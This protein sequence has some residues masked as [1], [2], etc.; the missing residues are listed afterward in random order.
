KQLVFRSNGT[1]KHTLAVPQGQLS[2]P[3]LGIRTHREAGM[4]TTRAGLGP[5]PCDSDACVDSDDPVGVGEQGIDI[6]LPYFRQIRSKLRD[7]D[8][9]ERHS[10]FVCT[11]DVTVRVENARDPRSGHE[12]GCKLKIKRR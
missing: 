9:G 1:N 6:E 8:E 12:L 7:L 5:R 11:R 2:L 3:F 10:S 4:P